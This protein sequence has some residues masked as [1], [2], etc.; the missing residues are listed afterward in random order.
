LA[1]TLNAHRLFF[2]A[3]DAE[4]DNYLRALTLDRR[5]DARLREAG[6][7]IRDELRAG[8]RNWEQFVTRSDMI[9]G[10]LLQKGLTP[11]PLR[12]KFR[13]QGSFAY[14]TVNEPTQLPHQQVDLDDGVFLPTSFL[15]DNG[16]YSPAVVSAGYFKAVEAILEPLRKRRNWRIEQKDTC[17]RLIIADDAHIDLPLYAIPD[18]EFVRLVETAAMAAGHI[19]AKADIE[20]SVEFAESVYRGIPV[21]KIMLA[22]R[23]EDWKESDP[24]KIEDWFNQAVKD[25]DQQLRR[26]C[27][28]LKGWR[29]FQWRR[30]PLSSI[31]IMKCVVDIYDDMLTPPSQSRDDLALL[32]VAERLPGKLEGPIDNPVLDQRLDDGWEDA[33]RETIVS[34]ANQLHHNMRAALLENSRPAAALGL[35]RQALGHR[36]PNDEGL[37]VAEPGPEEARILAVPATA[38]S[39]PAVPRTTSG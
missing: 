15:D 5:T 31:A 22:H 13:R 32:H 23:K 37:I 34:A 33:V 4:A 27:R 14:F 17:V 7:E 18:E 29:D 12:P 20:D 9:T 16:H 19:L 26:I 3:S 36:I 8:F 35:I 21:D 11:P 39:R 38:A 24:R 25:H 30:S 10:S 2:F 1:T 6:S 28:Y